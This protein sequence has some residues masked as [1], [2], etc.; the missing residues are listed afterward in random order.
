MN[1]NQSQKVKT[2]NYVALTTN[3]EGT[4]RM[5]NQIG[6]L[7]SRQSGYRYGLK[8]TWKRNEKNHLV[9]DY[10]D[11]AALTDGMNS[12]ILRSRLPTSKS[13]SEAV[14]LPSLIRILLA[15]VKHSIAASDSAEVSM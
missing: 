9:Y 15:A 5:I 6:W 7:S 11:A 13:W 14:A 8:I 1:G 12:N 3:M 4:E 10:A 2:T